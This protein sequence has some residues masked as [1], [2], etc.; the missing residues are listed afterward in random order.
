MIGLSSAATGE[1]RNS[2]HP[3]LKLRGQSSLLSLEYKHFL[4][5]LFVILDYSLLLQ[6]LYL[7]L[8]RNT[9]DKG[10]YTRRFGGNVPPILFLALNRGESS[11]SCCG[12]FTLRGWVAKQPVSTASDSEERYFCH[13]P[14][15]NCC[16]PIRNHL[17]H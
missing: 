15:S 12:R 13:C 9:A 11:A 10:I 1:R 16:R 6:N 2:P 4:N 17:L 3:Y 7:P 8:C 14:E 5:T